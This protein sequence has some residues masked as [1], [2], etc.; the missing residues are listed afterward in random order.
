MRNLL[1]GS[2]IATACLAAD[3]P[4]SPSLEAD[5]EYL[6]GT[7]DLM[8]AQL[9]MRLEVVPTDAAQV[10]LRTTGAEVAFLP[11]RDRIRFRQRLG[12]EREAA[13]LSFPAGTLAGLHVTRSGPGA[14]LLANRDGSLRLRLNADSLLMLRPSGAMAVS[15]SL[16]FEPAS[17]RRFGGDV[18]ALDEWGCV[19]T[20]LATGAGTAQVSNDTRSI[21]HTLMPGQVVWFSLG[22][23]RPFDWEASFRDRVVWHWS[24]KTG[25][26]TDAEIEAWAPYGNILLQQ[27]EVMLWKDWSLRF[28]PRLGLGEFQRVNRTC[29]RL[30]MRNI[31]YTSPFYFLTGTGLE[32]KAMNNFD[33]F[34]VTGF[35]P[36]DPRGLNWPIF[37]DQIATVMRGYRP[38]GLYFDGI[39]GSIVRT[40]LI[41]RKARELAGDHGLLEYHATGS[42]PGGGCYLPQIDTYYDFIL[43]GEGCPDQYTDP[44]YL[45]YF[46]STYN[47]SNSIGVLC[48]NND[49]KLDAAFLNTLLD[50]NIRLHLIP[51]WLADY[52]KQA[53]ERF[54]W[55]ALTPA[56]PARVEAAAAAR[57]AQF[58][59]RQQELHRALATPSGNWPTLWRADF[60]KTRLSAALPAPALAQGLETA[61]P[62][63]WTAFLSP[64]SEATVQAT[65][66]QLVISARAHTVVALQRDLPPEAA[67]VECRVLAQGDCGMSWGPGLCV[68]GGTGRARIGARSDGRLQTDR[69]GDQQLHEGYPP[70][71][72][73]W[74]R[75]RFVGP[76]VVFEASHDG[77][78]WTSLRAERMTALT[79]PRR[80]LIGKVPF[81]GGR[82]EHAEPGGMG[83][84]SVAD[85]S[86]Y[87]PLRQP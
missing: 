57:Q 87:A 24:M 53:L 6:L 14:A 77:K 63:G 35:S 32:D 44:D 46:V 8:Q 71:A 40:Y 26:P 28:I 22:P 69:P 45:R 17:V 25:Y 86:V 68:L 27:S 56:L 59:E 19:G 51:G 58:L 66:G 50:N 80:L 34:A 79:G 47:I 85:V 82:T 7:A 36:G 84:V 52:R 23:P 11:A 55:P 21:G 39:Y 64:R 30:G 70:G 49:Y 38:D 29:E 75:L 15:C 13:E 31:V 76:V 74:L 18:L 2:L 37:L 16:G 4:L 20:Y 65:D 73:Y 72:W 62:D 67:A 9:G 42:P 78:A 41:S 48:N 60:A 54:Y 61:L 43:R 5:A 1:S 3:P 83:T 33:N 10:V 81:D 12:R